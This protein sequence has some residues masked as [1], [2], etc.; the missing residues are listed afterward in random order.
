MLLVWRVNV[1]TSFFLLQKT[2]RVNNAES[3]GNRDIS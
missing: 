2:S 1:I 3:E